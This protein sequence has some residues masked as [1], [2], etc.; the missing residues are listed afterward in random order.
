[1]IKLFLDTNILIDLLAD[2]QPFSK[3]AA[4]ILRAADNKKAELY[5]SSHSI[6]T[7]YYILN[8]QIDDKSLRVILDDL[9]DF[10]YPIAIDNQIL[11]KALKSNIKDFE[12]AIQILAAK[13]IPNLD[14]IVTR[15][16]KDFKDADILVLSPDNAVELI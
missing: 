11:K 13:S 12:D 8:K 4:E 5:T 2:R 3:Y 10:I 1:M 9:M 7:T 16:I 15:N 14:A 6:A